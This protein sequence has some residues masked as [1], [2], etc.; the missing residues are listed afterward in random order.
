[1]ATPLYQAHGLLIPHPDDGFL[2]QGD[3]NAN[4][5]AIYSTVPEDERLLFQNGINVHLEN[6][7]PGRTLNTV[8]LTAW[9]MTQT[10]V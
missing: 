8:G 10:V 6:L 2:T 7:H 5:D 4:V 1:M 3:L 9:S